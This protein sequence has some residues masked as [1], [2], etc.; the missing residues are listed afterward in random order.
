MGWHSGMLFSLRFQK[1]LLCR[2]IHCVDGFI[3]FKI[4]GDCLCA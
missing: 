4:F 1:F 2:Q 3:V